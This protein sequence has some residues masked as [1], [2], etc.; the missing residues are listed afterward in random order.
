MGLA[1]DRGPEG[2]RVGVPELEAAG[3]VGRQRGLAADQ[4]DGGTALGSRL[5][6]RDRAGGEV[7]G[8]QPDLAGQL[9]PDFLPVQAPRDHQVDEHEDLALQRDHDPFAQAADAGHRA[10]HRLGGARIHRAQHEGVGEPDALEPRAANTRGQR[11]EVD[12]DV[13]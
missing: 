4:V 12:G 3:I 2:G 13:G 10:T 6:E 5:G 8:G 1:G 7:E 11:F 9:R